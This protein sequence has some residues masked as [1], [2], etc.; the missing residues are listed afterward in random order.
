MFHLNMH[1]APYIKSTDYIVHHSCIKCNQS[2][3]QKQKQKQ[4]PKK[5]ILH[6]YLTL[7][8]Q[9]C[10]SLGPYS[11]S[12]RCSLRPGGLIHDAIAAACHQ[13]A[14]FTMRS[15]QVGTKIPVAGNLNIGQRCV[16]GRKLRGPHQ[17]PRPK[18]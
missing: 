15:L 4:K 5:N 2:H 16:F 14:L 6:G 10:V 7:W 17:R 13:G 9:M 18:F 12:D 1:V 11:R 3:Q 8:K